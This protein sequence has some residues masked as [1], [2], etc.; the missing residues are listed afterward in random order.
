MFSLRSNKSESLSGS[1][2]L[3]PVARYT[4]SGNFAGW[5]VERQTI[6]K[7]SQDLSFNFIIGEHGCIDGMY[8]VQAY[9]SVGLILSL[10][11]PSSRKFR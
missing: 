5:A 4:A 8:K 6:G 11:H 9:K 10:A 2:G 1:F 3:T 7:L